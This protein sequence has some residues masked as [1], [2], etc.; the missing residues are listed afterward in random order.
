VTLAI[1]VTLDEFPSADRR[2]VAVGQTR[3][4]DDCDA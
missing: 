2:C 1:G 3:H 4:G